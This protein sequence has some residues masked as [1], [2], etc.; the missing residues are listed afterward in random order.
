[1]GSTRVLFTDATT[2]EASIAMKRQGFVETPE[3]GCFLSQKSPVRV[4][5]A[6]GK[7]LY[8]PDLLEQVS[9]TPRIQVHFKCSENTD[10]DSL[11]SETVRQLKQFS[12]DTVCTAFDINNKCEMS[13]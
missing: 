10:L 1:M 7:A 9:F 4:Y 3:G 13:L 12:Q 8:F 6:W 11:V 2:A 5:I